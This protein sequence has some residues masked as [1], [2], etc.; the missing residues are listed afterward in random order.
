MVEA[1]LSL[2]EA[3]EL[4]NAVHHYRIFVQSGK[5]SSAVLDSGFSELVDAMAEAMIDHPQEAREV[6]EVKALTTP[7]LEDAERAIRTLEESVDRAARERPPVPEPRTEE[8][9][10]DR[11]ERFERMKTRPVKLV[12]ERVKQLRDERG[13][14]VEGNTGTGQAQ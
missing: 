14:D 5:A 13:D 10:L 8:E 11:Q 7:S 9:R 6:L 1:R 2:L 3:T 12:I 4:M